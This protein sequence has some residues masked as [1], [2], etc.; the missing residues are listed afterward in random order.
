MTFFGVLTSFDT[1]RSLFGPK[2]VCLHLLGKKHLDVFWI[3][4]WKFARFF[5]NFEN[6][7]STVPWCVWRY[8]PA[9]SPVYS[10]PGNQLT[11]S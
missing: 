3:L 8:Q 11:Y 9:A 1:I 4:C 5:L 10:P 2:F 7:G 6:D